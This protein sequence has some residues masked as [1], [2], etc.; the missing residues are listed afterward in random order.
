MFSRARPICGSRLK[1]YL[2][3][4]L[5]SCSGRRQRV[6]YHLR[7]DVSSV[8]GILSAPATGDRPVVTGTGSEELRSVAICQHPKNMLKAKVE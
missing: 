7:A 5:P 4:S 2:K 3:C 1:T 8:Y 6:L